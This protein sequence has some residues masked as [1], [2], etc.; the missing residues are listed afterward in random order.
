MEGLKEG[1]GRG[2]GGNP[3]DMFFGGGGGGQRERG[4]KKAK[5]KLKEQS[6]TLEEVY[7]G[8]MIYIDHERYRLCEACDGKGGKDVKK[9]TTCKGKGMVTKMVQLGP[10]MYSQ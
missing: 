7:K 3:F 9:C 1:G 10:C 2:G 6:V 5:G 8:K 4:P